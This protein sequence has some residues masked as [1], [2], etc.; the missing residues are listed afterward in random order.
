MGWQTHTGQ[1]LLPVLC[2]F[3]VS[4][5]LLPISRVPSVTWGCWICHRV[6]SN[7]CQPANRCWSATPLRAASQRGK[8]P[9]RA[10]TICRRCQ[11]QRLPLFR[12]GCTSLRQESVGATSEGSEAQGLEAV[13]NRRQRAP[14]LASLTQP[15]QHQ[16]VSP[17]KSSHQKE[18]IRISSSTHRPCRARGTGVAIQGRTCTSCPMCCSKQ[19]PPL[20]G[21]ILPIS[22]TPQ[23]EC[24]MDGGSQRATLHLG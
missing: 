21:P 3:G 14:G 18:E 12:T 9:S 20:L 10:E 5:V 8:G 4:L 22:A 6:P 1:C 19:R 23:G 17:K 13:G 24:W 15:H 2:G 16:R 7:P 11:H